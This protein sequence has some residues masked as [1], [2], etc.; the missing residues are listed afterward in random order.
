MTRCR[1]R[2]RRG[3]LEPV[4]PAS[5]RARGRQ[6][7]VRSPSPRS[8]DVDA[9]AV[10]STQ[11]WCA[12]QSTSEPAAT[13]WPGGGRQA[14]DGRS[15][16]ADARAGIAEV[17][18]PYG[19]FDSRRGR[20][21]HRDRIARPAMRIAIDIDSTLHHYWDVLS[22]RRQAPLRHRAALRGAVHWG[23]T[24]LR[25]SSS[26]VCVDETPRRRGDPRGRPYPGAVETVNRWHAAGT[27]STSPAT[28]PTHCHHG[29]RRRWLRRHRPRL[30]RAVLLVRQGRA[31]AARSA[32]TC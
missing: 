11:R 10:H 22:R 21:R 4:L 8:I 5:R 31:A 20:A 32:S 13:T 27:S 24:R 2:R 7:M 12:R 14:V 1:G 6:T 26:R 3:V 15:G 16:A 25:P 17:A 23:I 19:R 29:D 9:P 28:A 30:R 18:A